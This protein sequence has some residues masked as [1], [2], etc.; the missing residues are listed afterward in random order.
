VRHTLILV[1][2]ALIVLPAALSPP[3][4]HDSFWLD[5]VWADQFTE[6]LSQG[7]LY[8]RWLPKSHGGLGSPVFYFYPPLAFYLSG[9]LGLAGLSTYASIIG[10]FA[11]GAAASGFTMMLWLKNAPRPLLGSVLFMVAPYHVY[12]FYGRGAQAEFLAVAFIPLLAYAMRDRRLVLIALAYAGLILS[13]LPLAL[14]T[15]IFLV[16]PY[17]LLLARNK[18]E[19]L[20]GIAAGLAL[21]LCLSAIYLIPALALEPYRDAT[22]LWAD[23]GFQAENWSI[24]SWSKPMREL[25]MKTIVIAIL[26][27]L[28][29]PIAL[30]FAAGQR[31]CAALAT[32]YCLIVIGIVPG[33]WSLPLLDKVQF[34]FRVFPLA[35]FAIATGLSYLQKPKPLVALVAV[36]ALTLSASFAVAP[37]QQTM[38]PAFLAAQHPDVPENLPPGLLPYSWPSWPALDVAE[39][40]PGAHFAFPSWR[41]S[42]GECKITMTRPERLGAALSFVT[43][44]LLLGLA[45]RKR[46]ANR[47]SATGGPGRTAELTGSK[48]Y[49][50][51]SL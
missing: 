38:E 17:G 3:M 40:Q 33:L 14:L 5:W 13:H 11:L 41:C 22:T 27:S 32:L 26:L 12:D 10:T 30:L 42:R 34:P 8:P 31:R 50:P 9:V 6:Q 4:T 1:L 24:W 19:R 23:P 47:P 37:K 46:G 49:E 7:N 16:G 35:E 36:P 18:A 51:P 48:A 29:A 21:G 45:R 15:S 2:A 39:R 43:L 25:G 28:A 20:P 44:L